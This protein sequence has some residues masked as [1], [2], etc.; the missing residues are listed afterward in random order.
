MDRI[1]R[2]ITD[3]GHSDWSFQDEEIKYLLTPH[4]DKSAKKPSNS[5]SLTASPEPCDSN[6]VDLIEY[7]VLDKASHF[8]R[9]ALK[10]GLY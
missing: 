2:G 5:S 4:F 3:D 10:I 6:G 7:C 1:D 8:W 9:S